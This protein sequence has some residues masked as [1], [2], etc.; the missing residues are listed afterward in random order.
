[1]GRWNYSNRQEADGLKK[2]EIRWLK[3]EGFLAGWRSSTMK[4][5][6]NG[7]ERG[8]IGIEVSLVGDLRGYYLGKPSGEPNMRLYYTQTDRTTEEK[9]DFDYKVPLTT[10]PCHFGGKRYWFICSLSVSG[11][12]CGRRVGV[13]YKD[14]DYFGCRH[15]YNLTYNSRNLSGFSKRAGQII[16]EPDLERLESEL[17]RK[18]YAGK[19]TRRYKSYLKKQNKS[20]LQ[21]QMVV[22]SLG[23]R[24]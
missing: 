1:M 15:C 22:N 23:R 8:S 6:R 20:L 7:E 24:F 10:T 14:G 5:S 16:G 3:K 9:K 11:R 12:Y 17:K 18:F 4:W 21:L 19:M 2:I 13:L